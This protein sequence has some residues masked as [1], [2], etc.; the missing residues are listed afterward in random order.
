[1]RYGSCYGR[2]TNRPGIAVPITNLPFDLVLAD[3]I[4]I[5]EALALC[6]LPLTL[7]ARCHR[8]PRR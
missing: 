1:M 2:K 5:W 3:T 7:S 6:A 8:C 4:E